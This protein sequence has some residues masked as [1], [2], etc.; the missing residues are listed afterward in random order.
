MA[1]LGGGQTSASRLKKEPSDV[2]ERQGKK[3]VCKLR[4]VNGDEVQKKVLPPC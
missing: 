4:A 3:T 1:D 2:M